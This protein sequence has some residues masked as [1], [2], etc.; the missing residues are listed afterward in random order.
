MAFNFGLNSKHKDQ[1]DDLSFLETFFSDAL[2]FYRNPL[3]QGIDEIM[4]HVIYR[5]ADNTPL[6][7]RKKM[8]VYPDERGAI[9]ESK[10]GGNIIY[11]SLEDFRKEWERENQPI[12][13]LRR[14]I[15]D[16]SS[17]GISDL[18]KHL[19]NEGK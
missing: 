9:I 16:I 10:D 18:T 4:G 7:I 15:T 6:E 3:A 5:L 14:L 13:P 11:A 19:P 1:I 12:P 17:H 2:L 8:S